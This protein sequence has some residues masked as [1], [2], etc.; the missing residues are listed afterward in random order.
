MFGATVVYLFLG[1]STKV[2]FVA[3]TL[4]GGCFVLYIWVRDDPPEYVQRHGDGAAGERATGKVLKPLLREGWHV[5]HNIDTGRGNRDHVVV[6][7]GGVFLLDSKNLGGTVTVEGDLVQVERGDDERDSYDVPKLA[8]AMR[9]QAFKLHNEIAEA[10]G[11]RTW[12]MAVVVFWSRFD[13]RIADGDRIVFLH[14]DELAEWLR[15]KP[16]SQA[17]AVTARI[18]EHIG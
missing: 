6:G 9:G 13:Q 4:A 17:E 11:V 12:V 2:Q 18:A 5:T 15:A 14:G 8:A 1:P 7:P 3:G 16:R 10:T